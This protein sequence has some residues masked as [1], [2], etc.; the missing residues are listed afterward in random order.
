MKEE[1]LITSN[2]VDDQ[3]EDTSTVQGFEVEMQLYQ[4]MQLRT[5]HGQFAMNV[6]VTSIL[7]QIYLDNDDSQ[8]NNDEEENSRDDPEDDFELMELEDDKNEA[9]LHNLMASTAL[10]GKSRGVDSKHLSKIRRIGHED[11]KKNN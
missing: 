2:F 9:L 8:G 10:A 1:E 11:A 6:G 7:D 4:S 5:E 3:N